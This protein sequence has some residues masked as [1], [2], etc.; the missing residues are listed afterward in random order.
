MTSAEDAA[1]KAWR[2]RGS[3]GFNTWDAWGELSQTQGPPSFTLVDEDLP[4]ST[5]SYRLPESLDT[6]TGEPQTEHAGRSVVHEHVWDVE[7]PDA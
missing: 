5:D 2:E 3:D 6:N 7:N 1:R 4:A